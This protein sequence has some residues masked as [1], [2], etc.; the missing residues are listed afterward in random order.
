M[1][2]L[3]GD[4]GGA[5]GHQM[6]RMCPPWPGQCPRVLSAQPRP[7]G[8]DHTPSDQTSSQYSDGDLRRSARSEF[9]SPARS[10]LLQIWDLM[11]D[12]GRVLAQAQWF[13]GSDA[14]NI[15]TG[16]ADITENGEH[17]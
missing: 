2:R 15:V 12:G 13:P 10:E 7:P 14:V 1:Q 16:D 5:I 4:T 9:S 11:S 3:S 8:A 6:C 17:F